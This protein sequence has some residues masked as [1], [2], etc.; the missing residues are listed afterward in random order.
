[1]KSLLRRLTLPLVLAFFGIVM[2]QIGYDTLK[3]RYIEYIPQNGPRQIFS[4]VESPAAF[5]VLSAGVC[6]VG[7]LLLPLSVYIFFR[8]PRTAAVGTPVQRSTTRPTWSRHLWRFADIGL[9]ALAVWTGYSETA[10]EKLRHTN[11]DAI[12]CLV[13]FVTMPL[14]VVGT[15]W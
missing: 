5:W 3:R 14:F 1:M 12:L 2:A 11:P 6:A 4:P 10:P 8:S 7:V 13:T 15:L 9:V